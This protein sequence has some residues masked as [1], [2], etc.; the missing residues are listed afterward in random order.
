MIFTQERTRQF[1]SHW[2]TVRHSLRCFG[3]N[4]LTATLLITLRAVINFFVVCYVCVLFTHFTVNVF[5]LTLHPMNHVWLV[6][7]LCLWIVFILSFSF[8]LWSTLSLGWYIHKIKLLLWLLLYSSSRH[9]QGYISVPK[10]SAEWK[11]LSADGGRHQSNPGFQRGSDSV[12]HSQYQILKHKN[13]K[14]KQA[15]K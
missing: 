6:F 5:R 9:L 7:K 4:S 10:Q 14:H 8:F 1:T 11:P 3:G 15:G 13:R 2:N 12:G